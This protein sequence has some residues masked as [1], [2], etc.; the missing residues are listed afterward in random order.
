MWSDHACDT[1]GCHYFLLMVNDFTRYMGVVLLAGKGNAAA[2]IRRIQATA[3][4]ECGR[5][6][7][8]IH[9]VN[10]HEFTSDEF[11]CHYEEHGVQC[12]FIVPYSP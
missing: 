1:L 8:V 2:S 4:A 9:T 3:R 6:L 11:A 12:Q 10:G 5:K 7:R